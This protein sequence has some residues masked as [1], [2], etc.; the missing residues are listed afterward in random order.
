[1]PQSRPIRD[2]SFTRWIIFVLLLAIIGYWV[3]QKLPQDHGGTHREHT[4]RSSR[5]VVKEPNRDRNAPADPPLTDFLPTST[6][7]VIVQHEG[8][9]LSY[10]EAFEQ[11]EWV[12]YTLTRDMM[13]GPQAKRNDN[14]RADDRIRTRSATPEDYRGSGYDRGHLCPASDMAYRETAM[15][16]TFLM[17]NISPQVRNFNGGIWRELEEDVKDWA[18]K[19]QKIYVVTG[20]VLKSGLKTIGKYNKVAVPEAYYK[21]ILNGK[22][23][24]AI[25]FLM[26][27]QTSNERIETYAT[28]VDEVE[29]LTKLNFFAK[30]MTPEQEAKVESKYATE[31]WPTSEKRYQIRLREWNQR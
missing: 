28:T 25:A 8:F 1:M 21:I 10:H 14:F 19:Y 31:Y 9:V 13:R 11:A 29:K 26:P 17:S 12:A 24:Q 20:P 6:T 15:D 22:L 5:E 30:L 18:R 27:N 23:D 3:W 7:G 2:N 16:E 4:E